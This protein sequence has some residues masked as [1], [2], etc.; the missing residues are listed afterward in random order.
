[1]QAHISIHSTYFFVKKTCLQRISAVNISD[2][3]VAKNIRFIGREYQVLLIFIDVE[4]IIKFQFHYLLTY[5]GRNMINKLKA[6][7]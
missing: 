3:N 7:G 1:M 4:I 5:F 2:D 6:V